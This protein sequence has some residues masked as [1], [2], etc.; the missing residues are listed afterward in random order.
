AIELDGKI[1]LVARVEGYDRK[2]FFAVAR[3]ANGIDNFEF[4]ALPVALPQ[5]TTPDVNVYDM[6]IT[7]HEDGFLYGTFC[8][9]RKDPSAPA[10]DTSSAVAACGIVRTK[11]L[12]EWERLDDLVS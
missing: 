6:R 7:A 4:D 11:D 2:S 9:E 3:S 10:H 1:C 12:V 5:A 8:T